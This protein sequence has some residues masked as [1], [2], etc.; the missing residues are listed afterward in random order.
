SEL[1]LPGGFVDIGET[2]QRAAVRELWEETGVRIAADEVR[3]FRTHSSELGDG[4]LL[5][6]GVVRSRTWAELGPF[7][8]Q[9]RDAS[10]MLVIKGKRKMAFPRHTQ[11]DE[12]YFDERATPRWPTGLGWGVRRLCS[13]QPP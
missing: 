2:W 12:G 5:I 6:F 3:H 1:A 8:P 10:E 13:G 4:I 9:D 7:S 11:G